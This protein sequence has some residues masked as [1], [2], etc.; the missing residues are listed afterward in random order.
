MWSLIQRSKF[1]KHA[2]AESEPARSKLAAIVLSGAVP[3]PAAGAGRARA[4][5]GY[6]VLD[7]T[8]TPSR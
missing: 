7:I 5:R 3:A 6:A 4:P 2:A 1:P 8:V